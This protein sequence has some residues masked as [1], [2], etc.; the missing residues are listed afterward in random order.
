M[1]EC[2]RA[3]VEA[4]VCSEARVEDGGKFG[5]GVEDGGVLKDDRQRWQCPR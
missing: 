3:V 4:V 1:T 5:A 2:F